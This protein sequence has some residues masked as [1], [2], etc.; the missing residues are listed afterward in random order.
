MG[1]GVLW[2][3]V[4]SRLA[5]R[6]VLLCFVYL[7]LLCASTVLPAFHP[8][9]QVTLLPRGGWYYPHFTIEE[10]CSVFNGIYFDVWK[11]V[12]VYERKKKHENLTQVKHFLNGIRQCSSTMRFLWQLLYRV[13]SSFFSLPTLVAVFF[14][15]S[16]PAIN[17]W[18]VPW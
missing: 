15:V 1:S 17:W 9:P 7:E 6:G 16:K 8:W 5:D 11:R 12:I 18:F 2:I 14:S 10:T 4:L 13:R 3:Q